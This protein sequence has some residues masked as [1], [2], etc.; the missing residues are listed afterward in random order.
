MSRPLFSGLVPPVGG[1]LGT[2]FETPSGRDFIALLEAFRA[3]GGTATGEIVARLLE[4]HQVGNAVSLA[5]LIYTGQVFSFEWRAKQ[6]I[7]MFQLDEYLAL[8]V[9]AQRVR[10][11]LPSLWSGWALAVWFAAPNTRLAGSS[12]ADMLD[13]DINAVLHAAQSVHAPEGFALAQRPHQVAGWA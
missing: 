13:S 6:W 12:P 4:E 11:E 5:K 9:G 2:A 10:S 8:K 3:T 7:P 1:G